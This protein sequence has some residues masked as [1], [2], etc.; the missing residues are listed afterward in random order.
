M[1]GRNQYGDITPA[2]SRSPWWGEINMATSPYLLGVP[3]VGRNQISREWMWWKPANWVRI[4]I[5]IKIPVFK[6]Q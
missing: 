6:Q 5:N 3:M 2:F 1:V 4:Q